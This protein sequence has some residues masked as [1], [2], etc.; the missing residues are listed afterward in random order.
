MACWFGF[1][2]RLDDFINIFRPIHDA[3]KAFE[4]KKS[5]NNLVHAKWL[6]LWK[7]FN[8]Q[9]AFSQ[10]DL[11][12]NEFF[13]LKLCQKLNKQ[14]SFSHRAAHY[15]HSDYIKKPFDLLKKGQILVFLKSYIT[16]DNHSWIENEIYNFWEKQNQFNSIKA[17]RKKCQWCNTFLVKNDTLKVMFLLELTNY[18]IVMCKPNSCLFY[19]PI[20]PNPCQFCAF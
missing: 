16:R 7:Y 13:A 6:E 5:I 9:V 10:F 19:K 2:I 14:I 20:I 11:D 3:K 4:P 18:C 15:L 8:Q 1:W 17:A 12:L